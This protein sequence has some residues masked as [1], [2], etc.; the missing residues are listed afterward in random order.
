[1]I[2]NALAD[3]NI[4]IYRFDKN[5][6]FHQKA[7]TFLTD[8]LNSLFITSKNISE[9]F[10]VTSKL[11]IDIQLCLNYQGNIKANT[12]ILFPTDKSLS[13]FENLVK[14]YQ[15]I[16]YQVY[17]IEI[18][19]IMLDNGLKDIATFNRK[20]FININEVRIIEL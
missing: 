12:T 7:K 18:V 1:M 14:K 4:L 8:P 16:G 20:D 11:K 10:A 9:F 5:S 3:T 17:D 19:S 13:I 2:N 6:I 15:P